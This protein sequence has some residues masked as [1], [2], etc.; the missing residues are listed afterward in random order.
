MYLSSEKKTLCYQLCSARYAAVR[1]NNCLKKTFVIKVA[2]MKIT[3]DLM[4]VRARYNEKL[5]KKLIQNKQTKKPTE[6]ATG[7]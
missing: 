4:K 3:D 2:I 6:V 5:R 7:L 1:I